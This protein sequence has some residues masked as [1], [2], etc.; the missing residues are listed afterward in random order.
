MEILQPAICLSEEGY[1]VSPVA[2]YHWD[3]GSADLLHPDNTH[4]GDLL[5]EGRAPT[6]GDVMPLLGN[7]FRV[8]DA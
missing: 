5:L 1:P 6:A 4:G 8:R 2:A 7:T 3:L